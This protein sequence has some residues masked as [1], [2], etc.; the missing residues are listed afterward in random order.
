MPLH[1]FSIPANAPLEAQGELN[2]FLA[3]HRIA[4]ITKQL[5]ASS[6]NA[7]WAICVESV[8][9]ATPLP[10]ALKGGF[11]NKPERVDYKQVLTDSQFL[12]YQN[13]REV[14][15]QLALA[16]GVPSYHLAT[17]VQLAAMVQKPVVCMADFATIDDFGTS[18]QQRY[19]Q[20]FLDALKPTGAV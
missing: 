1:F 16:E 6:E 15:K 2:Q 12:L 8:N 5:V 10:S 9:G 4:S 18:R 3:S 17:N 19:G 14:R 13:L 20:A 7:Y 11:A